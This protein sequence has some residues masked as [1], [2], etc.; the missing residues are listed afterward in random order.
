MRLNLCSTMRKW[1]F[2]DLPLWLRLETVALISLQ[3]LVFPPGRSVTETSR[4]VQRGNNQTWSTQSGLTATWRR[5]Q[6]RLCCDIFN[7]SNSRWIYFRS[8]QTEESWFF[9]FVNETFRE[10]MLFDIQTRS[11]VVSIH[12]FTFC[13][14][15]FWCKLKKCT[16]TL[17]LQCS[18]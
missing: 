6:A 3:K 15:I 11:C 8:C 7:Y 17:K 9:L 2:C 4:A 10:W 5:E 16:Y 14:M 12:F 1:I 18:K 13:I